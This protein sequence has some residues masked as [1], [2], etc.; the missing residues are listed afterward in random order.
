MRHQNLQ[1]I[2]QKIHVLFGVA[3]PEVFKR[4]VANHVARTL[5]FLLSEP[6][7]GYALAAPEVA[8]H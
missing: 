5:T 3:V 4:S 1:V 6:P 2:K 7:N 8:H